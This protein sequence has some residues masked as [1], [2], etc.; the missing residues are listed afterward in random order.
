MKE[1]AIEGFSSYRPGVPVDPIRGIDTG[2]AA[3]L[4]ADM[5]SR[6]QSALTIYRLN[7]EARRLERARILSYR[8]NAAR[9]L[10]L[11]VFA[12]PAGPAAYLPPF[13]YSPNTNETSDP[14][15]RAE[16]ATDERRWAERADLLSAMPPNTRRPFEYWLTCDHVLHYSLSA[17][18]L[19]QDLT[20]HAREVLITP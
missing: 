1:P 17:E 16:L 15:A 13:R 8:C 19:R 20:R 6:T 2:Q 18:Q 5:V 9:C 3:T 10:L 14:Q 7:R 11:D 12:T 4:S